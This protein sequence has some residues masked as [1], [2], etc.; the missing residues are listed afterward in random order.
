MERYPQHENKKRRFITCQYV[1]QDLFL[2]MHDV[3]MHKKDAI[4]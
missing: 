4:L 3:R 1:E 2:N